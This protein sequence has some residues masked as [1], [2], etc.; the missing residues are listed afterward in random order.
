MTDS[1]KNKGQKEI[2]ISQFLYAHVNGDPGSQRIVNLL[3]HF[4]H[5]GPNGSHECLVFELLGPSVNAI[6][7][8]YQSKELEFRPQIILEMT[9]R[10]LQAIAFMHRFHYAHGGMVRENCFGRTSTHLV[11]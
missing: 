11:E 1:G 6:I 9:A 5:K 2:D 4:I 10:L 3:D 8:E 7:K